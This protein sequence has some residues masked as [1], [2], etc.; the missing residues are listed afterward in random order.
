MYYIESKCNYAQITQIKEENMLEQK[1]EELTKAV[2]ELTQTIKNQ[3]GAPADTGSDTAKVDAA[4]DLFG[5][6]A[7]AE[8]KEVTIDDIRAQLKIYLDK[9]DAGAAKEKLAKFKATNLSGLKAE[10]YA[11][12]LK[13]IS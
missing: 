5:D 10:Q 2:V 4:D 1:I 8:T 11:D 7:T 12:F 13:E 6:T 9:N 3:K